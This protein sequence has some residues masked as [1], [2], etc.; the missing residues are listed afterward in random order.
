[1]TVHAQLSLPLVLIMGSML[2]CRS[3]SLTIAAGM[4]VGKSPFLRINSF[5]GNR[6]E[7]D[8]KAEREE[9]K[10]EMIL[11][12][13]KKLFESVGN[14]DLALLAATYMKWDNIKGGGGEK[15]RFCESL[16][17]SSNTIRDMRQM[18]NQLE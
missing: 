11:Q 6:G 15:R 13:R 18:V 3:A 1:M 16:G 4:S 14:S 12:E 8:E 5:R 7:L 2:G 9:L 17:L 10:N